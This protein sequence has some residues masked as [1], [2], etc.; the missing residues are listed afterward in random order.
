LSKLLRGN[1]V[2][3]TLPYQLGNEKGTLQ[4][5]VDGIEG[6]SLGPAARH[7]DVPEHSFYLDAQLGA[8]ARAFQY[9]LRVRDRHGRNWKRVEKKR[10]GRGRMRGNRAQGLVLYDHADALIDHSSTERIEREDL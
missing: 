8:N 6:R 7:T 9:L 2:P 5:W 1:W 10:L 4:L 3:P